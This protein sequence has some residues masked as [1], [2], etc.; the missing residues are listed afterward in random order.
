MPLKD[1]NP[2]AVGFVVEYN[3]FHN[4]HLYHLQQAKKETGAEVV[5]AVMSGSFLQRGEPAVV[6][7]WSR[8]KMAL[9]NGVDL[10]L[11]LPY[12]FAV[13]KAELFAKGAVS[14][15]S[16]AK[17]DY[18][19]FGSE[20]GAIEDFHVLHSFMKEHEDKWNEQVQLRMKEGYSYP[21]A[22]SLAFAH[23]EAKTQLSLDQPNNIL[24]YHYVKAIADLSS[25]LI[26]YTTKRHAAGF[27]DESISDSSIASATSI[28]LT[29]NDNPLPYDS[30]KK[31]MPAS[32]LE[33]LKQYE[34]R[35]NLLHTWESY[36]PFLQQRVLSSSIT[37][38]ASIYECEE[39]LEYRILDTIAKASTY[40]EWMNM[41]KTKRYTWTRL[42]RLATHLL[43]NTTKEE[44]NQLHTSE[45]PYI[46]PLGMTTAGQKHLRSLK[47]QISVPIIS[48]F[49][50]TNDPMATSELKA[51]R[52]YAAPLSAESKVDRLNEDYLSFP[53]RH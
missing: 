16:A 41:L 31:V 27:H 43:T 51:S 35:Y 52:S 14:I 18:L 17:A 48:R 39:G 5:I 24:G 28:R 20:S 49:A 53:I 10:L 37:E 47:K 13:Q 3:P 21:K 11:E 26:P 45:L 40:S 50:S 19:H 4:G 12:A 22:T 15:L 25:S 36:F 9:A 23:L 29:L 34:E 30:I 44:M 6:S 42:Q 1:T 7:K 8:T 38:L 2:R 32:A 46:R 33:E